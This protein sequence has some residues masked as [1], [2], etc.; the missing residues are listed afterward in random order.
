[1]TVEITWVDNTTEI[2]NANSGGMAS[3]IADPCI[4]DWKVI[5]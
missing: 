2:I 4:I 3:I 5:K 1:M